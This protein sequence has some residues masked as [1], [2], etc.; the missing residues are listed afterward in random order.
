MLV[1]A[2]AYTDYKPMLPGEDAGKSSDHGY[3]KV[4]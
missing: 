3:F 2:I 1:G 4:L